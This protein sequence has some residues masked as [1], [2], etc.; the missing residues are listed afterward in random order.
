M[1]NSMVGRKTW[2]H[3]LVPNA[4]VGSLERSSVPCIEVEGASGIHKTYTG[5]PTMQA[6]QCTGNPTK[7]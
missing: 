1:K 7:A 6:M 3:W 2:V 4:I 5:G